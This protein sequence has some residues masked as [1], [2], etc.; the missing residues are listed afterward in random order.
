MASGTDYGK[1]ENQERIS[2][3]CVGVTIY[4]SPMLGITIYS[5]LMSVSEKGMKVRNWKI[6]EGS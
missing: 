3:T 5:S 1:M 6:L 4:G 2:K